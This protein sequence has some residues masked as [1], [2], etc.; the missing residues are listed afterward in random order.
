ML[1]AMVNKPSVVSNSTG[2]QQTLQYMPKVMAVKHTCS[3][4]W[5]SLAVRK[6]KLNSELSAEHSEL[7]FETRMTAKQTPGS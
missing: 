2:S 6:K 7:T 5:L 3:S 1:V 4:I